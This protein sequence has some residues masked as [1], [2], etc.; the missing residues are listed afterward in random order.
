MTVLD[1]QTDGDTQTLPV[2]G[3]LGDIFTD[4]LGR[5]TERTDLREDVCQKLIWACIC[6]LGVIRATHLWGQSGRSTH[7]TTGG[8]EVDDLLLVGVELWRSRDVS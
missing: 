7:L 4:L 6:D 2:T 3:G 1:G 5:Q 8:T